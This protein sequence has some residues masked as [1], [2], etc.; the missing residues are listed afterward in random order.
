MSDTPQLAEW[1]IEGV[2]DALIYA[3]REGR[4]V[5]WNEA[6]SRLFGFTAAEA[7]GQSLDIIIPEH[8]R[9]AHWRGFDAAIARGATRLNGRPT[10]TRGLRKDG[11]R[12]Y[13]EMTFA[14][15][16]DPSGAVMGSVAMARDV[17]E[18]TEKER[19][20]RRAAEGAGPRQAG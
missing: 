14:L 19:A 11:A 9:E 17:T 18:R 13:V 10:L 4:I 3:D 7:L 8:L 16:K 2:S 1:I 5:R 20:A 12:L 6:S 15:V